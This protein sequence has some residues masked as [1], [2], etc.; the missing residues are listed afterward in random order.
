MQRLVIKCVNC[1]LLVIILIGVPSATSARFGDMQISSAP[2]MQMV[3]LWGF[4]FAAVG[5]ILTATIFIKSRKEQSLCAQWAFVF[6]G[7]LLLEYLFI[8]G[9]F[10]FEWLKQFLQWLQKHL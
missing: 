4:C 7:L 2:T 9:Y 1:A 6:G 5:N 10:N 8:H 3:T